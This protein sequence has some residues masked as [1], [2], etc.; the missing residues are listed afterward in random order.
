LEPEFVDVPSAEEVANGQGATDVPGT[1]MAWLSPGVPRSV[2]PNGMPEPLADPVVTPEI[3]LSELAPVDAW[4]E[5][6]AFEQAEEAVEPPPSNAALEV[7]F[8]HG[9]CSGLN[10]GGMSSVAPSGIPL[11]I[12]EEEA[13]DGEG[14]VPSGEVVPMPG[15]WPVC[16]QAPAILADHK[17]AAKMHV[18]RIDILAPN[19]G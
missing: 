10:P 5:L 6:L 3:E 4:E 12:E 7:V 11:P 13:E 19:A 18:P 15:V 17:I 2:A 9:I 16:A 14:A 1:V 8:G